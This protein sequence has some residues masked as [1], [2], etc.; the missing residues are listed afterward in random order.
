M[1]LT[2]FISLLGTAGS[3]VLKPKT[4]MLFSRSAGSG[5][6]T[7]TQIGFFKIQDD[8]TLMYVGNDDPI[9]A[10]FE[11]FQNVL[12]GYSPTKNQAVLWNK[13]GQFYGGNFTYRRHMIAYDMSDPDNP[14]RVANSTQNNSTGDD[15]IVPPISTEQVN[16]T[17]VGTNAFFF[18]NAVWRGNSTREPVQ[19]VGNGSASQYGPIQYQGS[20]ISGSGLTSNT[21][22]LYDED[23]GLF[24]AQINNSSGAPSYATYVADSVTRNSQFRFAANNSGDTSPVGIDVKRKLLFVQSNTTNA[25]AYRS[26]Q[27]TVYCLDYN[28]YPTVTLRSHLDIGPSYFQSS[29]PRVMVHD[30]K[31][32]YL[33]NIFS[34]GEGNPSSTR[35]GYYLVDTSDP[36]NIAT[37]TTGRVPGAIDTR[38]FDYDPAQNTGYFFGNN[39]DN[40]GNF[41]HKFVFSSSGIGFS[42]D[43]ATDPTS[44][45]NPSNYIDSTTLNNAT[46]LYG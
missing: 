12:Y 36:D 22:L 1:S 37:G 21:P 6:G 38:N 11:N 41:V 34:T 25:G 42:L 30:D 15:K 10:T 19:Y 28:N 3:N 14:V 17:G 5:I 23:A 24:F 43:V 46:L 4:H 7:G 39:A 16:A 27:K 9:D 31:F 32:Q 45:R 44:T 18:G 35:P 40:T 2:N 29:A 33:L 8:G 26:Y 13:S 20:S